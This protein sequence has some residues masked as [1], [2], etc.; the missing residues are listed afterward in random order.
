MAMMSR[1]L[2][3]L[4]LLSGPAF[5][6]A[7]KSDVDLDS[8]A[9]SNE[10]QVETQAQAGVPGLFDDLDRAIATL[11]KDDFDSSLASVGQARKEIAAILKLL[12]NNAEYQEVQLSLEKIDMVLQD[13]NMA[14]R[15]KRKGGALRFLQ[16][17]QRF[18]KSLAA[19]PV[20]KLTAA[21]VS[22]KL[23]NKEIAGGNYA[24]AGG[25]LERAID[26]LTSIMDNPSVNQNEIKALKND[27][28]ITHQQ[29]VLGKMKDRGYLSKLYDRASA[30]TTNALYQYYDMWTMDPNT[31]WSW[32]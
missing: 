18:T 15:S 12:D 16:A 7:P 21:K 22:I 23:A 26:A 9:M 10:V 8:S 14:I 24:S 6:Q 20:L 19:S 28:I 2:V 5:A 30:A 11:Q 32:Y 29:V 4:A 13:A 3:A 1:V 31:P 25:W 27:I 17:A